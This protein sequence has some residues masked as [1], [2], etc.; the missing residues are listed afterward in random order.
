VFVIAI[1][2]STF[3]SAVCRSASAFVV[4][5]CR[6]PASAPRR[7]D[8]INPTAAALGAG[9]PRC[10]IAHRQI[11]AVPLGLLTGI[12]VGAMRRCA[13]AVPPRVA[14]PDSPSRLFRFM[15]GV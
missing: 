11:S 8:E 3:S 9:E 13:P 1:S 10:P 4:I 15:F 6:P 14:G 7:D 5:Y 2:A 12:E